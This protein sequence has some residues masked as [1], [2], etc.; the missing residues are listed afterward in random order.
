MLK[1]HKVTF[2]PQK[3]NLKF[4]PSYQFLLLSGNVLFCYCH[5]N[6]MSECVV[7]IFG[8]SDCEEVLLILGSFIYILIRHL[9]SNIFDIDSILMIL[10]HFCSMVIN[11][12]QNRR[13]PPLG[14]CGFFSGCYS[15][16]IAKIMSWS[17][18]NELYL[19]SSAVVT[20]T[21]RKPQP[22]DFCY[23]LSVS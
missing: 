21:C 13:F 5:Q 14:T 17:L 18:L 16:E 8:K 19:R 22:D 1:L 3:K 12:G 2:L 15:Y 6:S 20:N 9:A 11:V 10:N 4:L 7:F 23:F